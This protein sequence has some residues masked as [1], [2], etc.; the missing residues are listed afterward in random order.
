MIK[1]NTHATGVMLIIQLSMYLQELNNA[2]VF[3]FILFGLVFFFTR[4]FQSHPHTKKQWG[5][6]SHY[7][8]TSEP[9]VSDGVKLCKPTDQPAHDLSQHPFNLPL[10]YVFFF[11]SQELMDTAIE[12]VC[13]K[14]SEKKKL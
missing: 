7:T 3:G 9:V 14:K 10:C 8:D 2:Y 11:W 12:D 6:W 1:T 5:G 13:S 4:L